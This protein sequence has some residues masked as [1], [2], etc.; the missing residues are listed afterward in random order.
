MA[1]F[2]QYVALR[3]KHLAAGAA[4]VVATAPAIPDGAGVIAQ[5]VDGKPMLSVYFDTAKADV[6]PSLA[7]KAEPGDNPGGS[8]GKMTPE[9]LVAQTCCRGPSLPEIRNR[10]VP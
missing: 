2:G 5:D 8:F 4:P 3:E 7:A 9:W 1:V 10:C 6:D